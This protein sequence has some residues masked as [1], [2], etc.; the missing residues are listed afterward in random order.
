MEILGQ[1]TMKG[2]RW[3]VKELFQK[4]M[5]ISEIAKTLNLSYHQ[6]YHMLR[7]EPQRTEDWRVAY[8]EKLKKHGLDEKLKKL[9]LLKE[10]RKGRTFY[11]SLREVKRRLEM[12]LLICGIPKLKKTRWYEFLRFFV[13]TEMGMTWE[14]FIAKREEKV[15][16]KGSITRE[17]GV[18]EIDA[19][20]YSFGG[21]NYSVMLAMDLFSGFILSYMVVENKEK[22]AKHYNKA[23]DRFEVAK[24]LQDTFLAYGVPKI[25]KSDNEKVIKNEYVQ[26]ALE[27]LGVKH[28][29]TTPG[30][31]QQKLI[32]NAIGKLK[33]Y[34]TG[35]KTNSIEDLLDYAINR[36]NK[37]VHRF[38]DFDK[39][40]IPAEVFREY[41]KRDEEEILKAF[42]LKV[43]RVLRN[44]TISING[45]VYEFIYPGTV[46]VEALIYLDDNTKAELYDAKTGEFLGIAR[47]VSRSLGDTLPEESQKR[48]KV[49]RIE[50]RQKRYEEEIRRLQEEKQRVFEETPSLEI[51]EREEK[52]EG[53]LVDEL[54]KKIKEEELW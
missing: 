13:S 22:D 38:K 4:G 14:E 46:E 7:Y 5:T 30:Q 16:P 11:I 3:K 39:P 2:L 25:L 54:A 17:E 35:I 24:L 1:I 47:K 23:F 15:L 29:K 48:R 10:E 33:A 36:W 21:K 37:S 41:E 32:E 50:R 9:L 28:L 34:T 53:S 26:K 6:V 43:K 31:P 19:T 18:M 8:L 42:A 52:G 45:I 27:S 12:E 44:N 51:E 40:I 49:K 20:G